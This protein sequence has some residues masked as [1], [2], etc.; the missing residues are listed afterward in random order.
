MALAARGEGLNLVRANIAEPGR[1][2]DDERTIV[3]RKGLL[4]CEE[5][6]YLWHELVHADRRDRACHGGEAVERYV[7]R[8]AVRRAI[9]TAS[10]QWAAYQTE[11]LHDL[12]D[13]LKLPQPWVEFRWRTA[14]RWEK[15]L[16]RAADPVHGVHNSTPTDP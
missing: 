1:Y 14:P 9:P 16:V 8:V 10:L 11:T 13:L 12:A 4:I 15:D 6:R 5:R 2:Y 7:E 3:I